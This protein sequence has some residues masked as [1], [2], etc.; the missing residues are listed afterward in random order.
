MTTKKQLRANR[1]NAKKSTGPKSATGKAIVA[2]NAIKSG[3]H[4]KPAKEA[5]Q[6]AKATSLTPR[7]QSVIAELRPNGELESYFAQEVAMSI[8]ASSRLS[9]ILQQ[10]REARINRQKLAYVEAHYE[11]LRK[12]KGWAKPPRFKFFRFTDKIT[13]EMLA[14]QV[15]KIEEVSGPEYDLAQH[16]EVLRHAHEVL[17]VEKLGLNTSDGQSYT[18]P[19][20]ESLVGVDVE[21]AQAWVRERVASELNTF[22][23]RVIQHENNKLSEMSIILSFAG[24]FSEIETA[25]SIPTLEELE[26]ENRMRGRCIRKAKDGISVVIFLQNHT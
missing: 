17:T 3:L 14:A 26:F 16:P 5:L 23:R 7:Y 20:P 11:R 12:E 1:R 24:P 13:P 8:E 6:P 22:R 10:Q 9:S 18:D 2:S 21:A 25:E 19:T 15:R 4:S